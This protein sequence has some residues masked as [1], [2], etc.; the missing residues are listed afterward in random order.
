MH[1]SGN[2]HVEVEATI[3]FLIVINLLFCIIKRGAISAMH[4]QRMYYSA[5]YFQLRD[6]TG[7]ES[8][9]RDLIR[10]D[11]DTFWPVDPTRSLSARCF[12]LRDYFDVGVLQVNAFCQKSLVYAAHI[13]ITTISNIIVSLFNIEK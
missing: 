13:Q 6:G 7:S 5:T 9:T 2:H 1:V 12:E 11:P 8:L 3:S 10:P 4:V